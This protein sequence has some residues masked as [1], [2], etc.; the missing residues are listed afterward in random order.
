MALAHAVSVAGHPAIFMP[1]AAGLSAVVA[2]APEDLTRT[3]LT[4]AGGAAAAVMLYSFVQVRRGKW[5]DTDA[6][7]P[8]ERSELNLFLAPLLTAGAVWAWW[9]AQA[10]EIALGLGLS[11]VIIATSLVMS[12]W[13]KLSLHTAFAVFGAGLFWPEILIVAAG[14]GMAG[15]IAWSRLYLR[16]HTLADVNMGAGAGALAAA[17]FHILPAV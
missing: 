16:R 1:L 17:A 15:L 13:V 7:V 9:S 4:V 11:A 5:A 12:R 3:V 14:A 2:G 6:S 8:E 10:P